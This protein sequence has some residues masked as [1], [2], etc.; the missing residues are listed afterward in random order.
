MSHDE[1]A[2]TLCMLGVQVA[3]ESTGS[4]DKRET[5]VQGWLDENL[6][7]EE[8]TGS[9]DA[10]T[11][12]ESLA[13]EPAQ[14]RGAKAE[15]ST[16]MTQPDDLAEQP[17]SSDAARPASMIS[18]EQVY[19]PM[20]DM[21]PAAAAAEPEPEEQEELPGEVLH[22]PKLTATA[23]VVVTGGSEVHAVHV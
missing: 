11:S 8:A 23:T 14:A 10:T 2:V 1:Y 16:A 13:S 12:A 18:S 22:E 21:V 9:G 15:D 4:D 5:I 19:S 20:D 17:L 7:S 3:T 6:S